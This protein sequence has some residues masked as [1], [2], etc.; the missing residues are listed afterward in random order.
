MAGC[1]PRLR[2]SRH[3]DRD[4]WGPTRTPTASVPRARMPDFTPMALTLRSRH[5]VAEDTRGWVACSVTSDPQ[6]ERRNFRLFG[7]DET[8]SNVSSGIRGD[9]PTMGGRTVADDEFLAPEGGSWR[10]SA[11][12]SARAGWKAIC[13]RGA[14]GCSTLRSVRSHRRLDVQ[15]AREMA[16]V[17]PLPWRRDSHR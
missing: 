17:T 15:P 9:R 8:L 1:C 7:P 2:R 10:C 12:I 13:S 3:Q 11:S 6:C 5:H 16:Q 4:G 14:T